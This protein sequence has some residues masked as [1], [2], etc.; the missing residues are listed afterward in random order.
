M[1]D[2]NPITVPVTG[3]GLW[4][5]YEPLAAR[6]V[7]VPAARVDPSA[8]HLGL[9]PELVQSLGLLPAGA[10]GRMF[11]AVRLTILDRTATMD[12]RQ[13]GDG[14]PVTVGRLPLAHL[15]LVIDV[16]S[17]SVTGNPAYGGEWVV[18]MY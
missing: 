10:D 3:E 5:N 16:Q 1:A 14:D 17:R 18:E 11:A 7:D 2:P 15:D 8:Q 6:R 12:V 13:L 9:P 4:G